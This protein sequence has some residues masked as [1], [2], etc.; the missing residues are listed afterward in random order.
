MA[1]NRAKKEEPRPD[2]RWVHYTEVAPWADNPNVHPQFQPETIA[3]S[4]RLFG[5][6][7][8]AVVWASE[9]RLVAGHGRLQA[10]RLIIE[11]GYDYIDRDGEFQHRDPDPG[12][13]PLGAP[14]PGYMAVLFHDFASEAAAVEAL[15][16]GPV[17][18]DFKNRMNPQSPSREKLEE[19]RAAKWGADWKQK[20]PSI[21]AKTVWD[22][23][24][25]AWVTPDEAK[26]RGLR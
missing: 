16:A 18:G 20:Y 26:K 22:S 10:M 17:G 21:A 25:A 7:S 3:E 8:P 1:E 5:F 9:G 13:T 14:G 4:I 23:R 2:V 19:L 24:R 12:F 15:L 6:V 11:S